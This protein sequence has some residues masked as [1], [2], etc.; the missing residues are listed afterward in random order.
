MAFSS[1]A[2]LFYFWPLSLL[3]YWAFSFSRSLQN[4]VLVGLSLAFYAWGEPTYWS[5][6]IVTLLIN[7]LFGLSFSLFKPSSKG[8]LVLYI[9]GVVFNLSLLIGLKYVPFLSKSFNAMTA[10]WVPALSWLFPIGIS[11]YI[12]SAISYLSDVYRQTTPVEKNLISLSLY[13][14]FFPKILQGP[15]MRYADFAPQIGKRDMNL[16]KLAEGGSRFIIGM[17]KK[18]LIANQMGIVADR[19]F[20]LQAMDS[21]SMG[22]AWLGMIAY[23]LQIYYD[24]S[25]YSDMA[26]GIAKLFGFNLMENFNYPY[27]SKSIGDFWRR[28]HISLGDWFKH[29]VYFPLG[30]SRM[31]NQDLVLRNLAIVWLATGLW[32]GANWTFLVWGI[33]NFLF[34]AFERMIDFDKRKLSSGFRHAYAMLVVMLGW[35][36]FRSDTLTVAGLYIRTLFN[37][38]SGPIAGAS[39]W[40]FL[41]EYGVYFL[42]GII[43]S[44][45]IAPKV[46]R[47]LTDGITIRQRFSRKGAV[48]DHR[49]AESI[50]FQKVF[51]VMYPVM[52]LALFFVSVVYILKGTYTS[53]LYFQF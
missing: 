32:H 24:F 4:I 30:G 14:A 27:S 47:W 34:I 15:I 44:M 49:I 36:I 21:L 41:R 51:T 20:E 10:G 2:F 11:F 50:S 52:M 23:T 38:F 28:W 42:I 43:F 46:T 3:V 35:V 16:D 39:T 7:Y 29:Y 5:L 26:L 17:A 31:K 25:G 12:F 22:L 8:R 48:A 45:P 37:P 19:V 40:L 1:I 13:F 18:V 53:F 33:W 6:L 9:V